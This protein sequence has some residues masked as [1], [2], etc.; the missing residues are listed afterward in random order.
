MLFNEQEFR[1]CLKKTGKSMR[2]IAEI[3]GIDESTMYRK[4]QRNGDFRREEINVLIKEMEI[5]NP[6]KIFFN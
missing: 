1:K 4:I 2:G 5:E 6:E 3:L